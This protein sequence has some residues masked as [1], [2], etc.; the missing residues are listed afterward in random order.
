MKRLKY[1]A[2]EFYEQV[3][4]VLCVFFSLSHDNKMAS[5]WSCHTDLDL[6]N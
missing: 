1:L 5:S 6:A 3:K 2:F 4:G